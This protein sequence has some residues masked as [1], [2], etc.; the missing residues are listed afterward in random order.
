MIHVMLARKVDFK[1]VFSP[2]ASCNELIMLFAA[3]QQ[4][5]VLVVEKEILLISK[6]LIAN[7][8]KPL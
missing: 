4:E 7:V 2:Q 3:R 6:E 8:L 5:H 1:Q